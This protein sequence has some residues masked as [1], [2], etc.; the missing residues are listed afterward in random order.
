MKDCSYHLGDTKIFLQKE[1]VLCLESLR[2]EKIRKILL[3]V[4]REE[5]IFRE[6]FQNNLNNISNYEKTDADEERL[7][8]KIIIVQKCVRFYLAK[9]LLQKL[10][11]KKESET[12]YKILNRELVEKT[13]Q[14][15]KKMEHHVSICKIFL[16]N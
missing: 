6:I 10:L 8:N 11:L 2:E 4:K 1:A 9:K 16:I 13:A 14:I 5:Y 15:V 12:L 3:P 7:L